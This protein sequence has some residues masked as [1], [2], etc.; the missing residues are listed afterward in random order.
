MTPFPFHLIPL[1]VSTFARETPSS[2]LRLGTW[3]LRPFLILVTT[4]FWLFEHESCHKG[5]C[6]TGT[7][8][9]DSVMSSVP[10]WWAGR[11]S[12]AW[13]CE[14]AVR[15]TET[16]GR[17]PGL[18][19]FQLAPVGEE[20][21]FGEMLICTWFAQDLNSASE[22]GTNEVF[23]TSVSLALMCWGLNT[24]SW[25]EQ[26]E[27]GAFHVSAILTF[28]TLQR[29]DL[30]QFLQVEGERTVCHHPYFMDKET[31]I[32]WLGHLSREAKWPTAMNSEA[33]CWEPQTEAEHF[34]YLWNLHFS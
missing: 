32:A 33:Q 26:R 2:E 3:T 16:A 5:S 30:I 34:L 28:S 10:L 31:K 17:K 19:E 12:K 7:E 14:D 6:D 4:W 1:L 23:L 15:L 25:K 13:Q 20:L 21:G 18:P 27:G 29:V 24:C 8:L 11:S 9:Q 22:G